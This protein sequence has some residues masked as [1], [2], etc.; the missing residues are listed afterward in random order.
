MICPGCGKEAEAGFSFCKYC[1]TKLTADR[2]EQVPVNMPN[3]ANMPP[4][5]YAQGGMP[6]GPSYGPSYGPYGRNFQ[7][8]YGA[9][10]GYGMQSGYPGYRMP[11]GAPY[12]GYG[13][14]TGYMPYPPYGQYVPV[15][16]T[17]EE[18]EEEPE[19]DMSTPEGRKDIGL[20]ISAVIVLALMLAIVLIVPSGKTEKNDEIVTEEELDI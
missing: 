1:G 4:Y 12:P 6:Y 19:V 9:P 15:Q 17:T 5:G 7:N 3:T 16:D 20:Y 11:T 8:G 18:D 14:N 13:Q 2:Q 10:N